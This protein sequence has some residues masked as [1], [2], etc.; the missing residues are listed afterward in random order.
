MLFLVR[1]WGS[2]NCL[3]EYGLLILFILGDRRLHMETL[4]ELSFLR[5][6]L[7]RS[8]LRSTN[9]SIRG[10]KSASYELDA[11]LLTFPPSPLSMLML[12]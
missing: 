3:L 9:Y 12:P 1:V 6:G 7:G 2:C 5:F 4:G 10:Y 11:M 8:V